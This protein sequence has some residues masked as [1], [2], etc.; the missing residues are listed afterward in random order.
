MVSAA[1]IGESDD[2]AALRVMQQGGRPRLMALRIVIVLVL[3]MAAQAYDGSLHALSHWIILGLYGLGTL[4]FGLAERR[5]GPDAGAS[6]LAGTG[7]NALL[8]VYVI[9]EH[10]MAGGGTGEGADAVSRLPAYLLLLQTGLSMQVS[11]T[12]LFCGLVTASWVGAFLMGLA[13]P[14]LF[15]GF[16]G[17]VPMQVIGLS[18][19]VATGLLVA[20]GVA[21]LR[22]AVDRTLQVERERGR[23]ARFVPNAI[24]RDLASDA[25]GVHRRHACLLILD[26]R[27]FSALSREHPPEEMVAALMEVRAQAQGAVAAQG[28]IVDKYIGDAVLAQFVT[29]SA[30]D[31]ARAA[32]ACALD[33]QVRLAAVN[34]GRRAAGLFAIR[35]ASALHAGDLL[36]G[37]FDDGVRAEYTVLGPAMNTLARIEAQAKAAGLAVAASEAIV[38]LLGGPQAAP[39][40]PRPVPGSAAA[41]LGPLY[42]LDPDA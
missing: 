32:A 24:A 5:R 2:D 19:F 15:P 13:Y 21:R 23:L 30:Q 1:R 26:I 40:R 18:A 17:D 31:Q 38:A 22:R 12:L 39:F 36:V 11:H 10:M 29:G 3:L 35:T 27:G 8:A 37:V 9:V 34:A 33:L 41:E 16:N 20:D 42:A 4:W 25:L 7:L 6:S 28:G 14:H